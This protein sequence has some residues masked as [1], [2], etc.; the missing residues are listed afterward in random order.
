MSRTKNS[1]KNSAMAMIYYFVSLLLQFFSRKVFLDYLGTEILGLNTTASNLLQ[2]LNL[3]EL[4]ISSA[5]GF[6]LY[7]PLHDHDEQGVNEIV[8]LQGHLYRRIAFVVIGGAIILMAFFP[9]IFEKMKL[10]LW[11]AYATFGVLLFSA[12]LGYFV[13]YK[14]IVLTASQQDYKVLYSY[15]T[16]NLLKI[17]LQMAAVYYFKNGYV[18]WLILEV[19]GALASSVALSIMTR[20]SFP[21][22]RKS[23][24]PFKALRSKYPE[25]SIKIKQLF[26]HKIGSY[27][28][29]QTAPLII[30]AFTTLTV[31]ALYGNYLIVFAGLSVLG[32]QLFN[33]VNASVGDLAAEG[34]KQKSFK[35]FCEL[36]SV[37]FLIVATLCFLS[38]ELTPMFISIWIGPEYLLPESTLLLMI[39]TL[40]INTLRYAV[41]AFI[42]AYGLFQDIWSPV[43]EAILNIGLS[44][45]FG[46]HWGLNGVIAGGLASLVIIIV[47]WKPLFLFITAF[48]GYY[49]KYLS[50][51]GIHLILGI[52]STVIA[53][54]I[55]NLLP[56]TEPTIL[57]LCYKALASI[58]VFTI[59]LI[60][61]LIL[62]RTPFTAFLTRLKKLR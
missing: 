43:A 54:F 23:L 1:L 32:G 45:A 5:V 13:N 62:C 4:G 30:Y 25:F 17:L 9:L 7:K 24:L 56:A 51:Y 61:L 44:I 12:L 48:K 40:Y 21:N 10:P 60:A 8:T 58:I 55:L 36:F 29:T 59:P 34:N 20:R 22:L 14:Q 38:Y 49:L 41:D 46:F 11:Y 26:F 57:G 19:A 42:N 16:V 33:G 15:K 47:G 35:V 18:W 3:A 50:L 52:L 28:L 2:F 6:T 31:V 39:A 37:R 27:A 53:I